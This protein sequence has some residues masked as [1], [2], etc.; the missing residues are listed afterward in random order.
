MILRLPKSMLSTASP[1]RKFDGRSRSS[2]AE[3][4]LPL[5]NCAIKTLDPALFLP[6]FLVLSLQTWIS[7]LPCDTPSTGSSIQGLKTAHRR[8]NHHPSL[9]E[10]GFSHLDSGC[11]DLQYWNDRLRT[12]VS[13]RVGF[14]C[15]MH[16]FR[17]TFVRFWPDE[18][19]QSCCCTHKLQ[20]SLA[21]QAL[22]ADIWFHLEGWIALK[23]K[24]ECRPLIAGSLN[25]VEAE[26]RS[27]KAY[28]SIEF[29][30]GAT[31]CS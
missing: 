31:R 18:R 24:L 22:A 8:F 25:H 3:Y 13:C 11:N 5:V 7:T 20:G 27:L 28:L 29:E 1:R 21:Y 4:R 14:C 17:S 23:H 26:W 15:R 10:T 9:A 2:K 12:D 19:G 16:I 6:P 30:I